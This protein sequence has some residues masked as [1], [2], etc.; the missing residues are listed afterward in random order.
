MTD[1]RIFLAISAL[2]CLGVFANGW[3][4]ARMTKNPFAGRK[5]GGLPIQGSELS[6]HQLRRIGKL[7]MLAAVIMLPLFAALSFGLLG[8]VDGIQTINQPT[9]VR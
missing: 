6:I 2:I 4:F 5:L 8:P 7:Q 1:G 3:R 9:T